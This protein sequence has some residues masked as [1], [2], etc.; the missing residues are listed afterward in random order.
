MALPG[1]AEPIQQ[2]LANGLVAN[3]DYHR[4][5]G[6]KA[7]LVLHGFLATHHFPTIQNIT[8]ELRDSGYSVLAPTLTLGIN[9]R[10]TSLPCS[11]LHLHTMQDTVQELGWWVN[12]LAAQGYSNIYLIGHSSGAVQVLAYSLNQPHPA[13]RR[14][15]LAS[16]VSLERLPGAKPAGASVE[17]ARQWLA[18][19]DKHIAKYDVSFCHGNFTAP[20]GVFLSYHQ[21][22]QQR[23]SEAL[24]ETRVP[25]TVIMGGKDQRFTGTAWMP[26]L[27]QSAPR[28]LVL[29]EANHFFDGMA[30]F[31]LLESISAELQREPPARN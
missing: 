22:D 4:G 2:R 17:Q 3:A 21:W 6:D 25:T 1:Q 18:S 9:N 19:G 27:Q 8:G 20:A 14:Q 12:W 15:I 30:E 7:V 31:S 23:I 26:R 10:T 16:L 24:H 5:P 29:P 11:A 13:V 28:L